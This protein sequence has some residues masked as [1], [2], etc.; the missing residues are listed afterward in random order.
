MKKLVIIALGGNELA[1]VTKGKSP[2]IKDQFRQ[3]LQTTENISEFLLCNPKLG[4]ALTHGNG[5]QVGTRLLRSYIAE[6]SKEK[7]PPSTL[8]ICGADTQGSIGYMIAHSMHSSLKKRGITRQVSSVVTQTLVSKSD[9]AFRKPTKFIG[10]GYTKANMMNRKASEVKD[11]Q[12]KIL[13]FILAEDK[14]KVI[15]RKYKEN[16]FRKVVASPN[17]IDI[18][19]FDAI[20]SLIE[21]DIITISVGGGGIPVFEQGYR[22]LGVDAV[23]DKDLASAL[24][25]KKLVEKGFSVE[26]VILTAVDC[27]YLNFGKKDIEYSI[28]KMTVD[29]AKM[30]IAEGQFP[31]GSML[32]KIEAAIF[33]VEN[34]VK[35]AIITSPNWLNKAYDGSAG[36]TISLK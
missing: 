13:E 20:F 27:V 16:L 35:R 10:P 34:G 30:H 1:P 19:E 22:L 26:L 36:T 21:K 17:P 32:P 7:E 24:L 28:P 8:N 4:I 12:G 29:E 14:K 11:K 33:A 25:A 18:I 15:Y 31:P 9:K 3:T 5:P 23:I 2:S 6:H